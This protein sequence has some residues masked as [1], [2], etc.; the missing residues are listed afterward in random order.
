M[1]REHSQH[2]LQLLLALNLFF[3]YLINLPLEAVISFAE[4]NGHAGLGGGLLH[5]L[6]ELPTHLV[7]YLLRLALLP[8]K[9]GLLMVES[10]ELQVGLHIFSS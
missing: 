7:D 8:L 10:L 1:G 4:L 5:L 9:A 3:L 6:L 2:G